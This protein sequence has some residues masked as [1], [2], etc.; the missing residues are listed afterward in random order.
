MKHRSA[1]PAVGAGTRRRLARAAVVA[2][3]VTALSGAA[4]VYEFDAYAAPIRYEAESAPATCSGT[5]GTNH[6]GFSGSG[7]CDTPN[8]VGAAAEFTVDASAA[9]TAT[10]GIRYA[11]RLERR[12]NIRYAGPA[13][14]HDGGHLR[15]G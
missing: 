9:G 8:A 10:L 5:I 4:S 11:K 12:P 1:L 7:F 6:S 3:A 14:A 15:H 13:V 2:T